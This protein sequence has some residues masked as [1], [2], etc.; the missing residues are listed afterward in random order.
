MFY[1]F[2]EKILELER[3]GKKIMKMH[4]GNTN[5][6]MPKAA[7]EAAMKSMKNGK[8]GYGSSAGLLELRQAIAE[9]EKC[10]VENVV[11]GPGSKHL[12]FALFS[13]LKKKVFFPSP[14]WPAYELACRQLGLDYAKIPTSFENNWQLKDSEVEPESVFVLCNPLNPTSTVYGQASVKKLLEECAQKNS[15]AVLD[16][17]YKGLSFEKIPL[18]DAMRVR[19]FS[20]E[21]NMEEWRLAY[22]VGPKDLVDKI[23]NFNQITV[24][25]VPEFVQRAGIACL[26]NEKQILY[27]NR[28]KWLLRKNAAVKALKKNGFGFAMP[29][30]GIYCFATHEKITDS[31]KFAFSL[32]E[33]GIAVS[34]GTSF[35]EQGS[36]VRLCLNQDEK[37]L[38]Q[39]IEKMAE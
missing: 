14:H 35:G 7:L 28:K 16:E 25:C 8:G 27:E 2:A 23:I 5:L 39:A 10:G 31:E 11:V 4:L 37:T 30:S 26:E 1:D 22:L 36:F 17:A 34:A 19:S 38:S 3:Q 15:L 33:K 29:S 18:Y 32:L 24:T 21:F 12:L 20:K 13:V 6:P 9:R